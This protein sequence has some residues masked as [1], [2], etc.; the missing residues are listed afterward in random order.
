MINFYGIPNQGIFEGKF[1]D[2]SPDLS[3]F[4]TQVTGFSHS[5]TKPILP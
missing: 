5:N 2:E 1:N 4:G 3:S